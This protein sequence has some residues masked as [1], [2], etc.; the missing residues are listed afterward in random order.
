MKI[1]FIIDGWLNFC[2]IVE[3]VKK[4]SDRKQEDGGAGLV[5]IQH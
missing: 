1:F 5:D 4:N 3:I 2:Y